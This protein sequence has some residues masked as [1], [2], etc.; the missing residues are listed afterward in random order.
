MAIAHLQGVGVGQLEDDQPRRPHAVAAAA[1]VLV[2]GPQDHA[3][4][5]ADA[6]DAAV[7]RGAEDD[8]GE[9]R[10]LLQPA[11]RGQ[12]NLR[13]LPPRHRLLA[14]LSAGHL[15]VLLPQRGHHVA[16]REVPRSKLLRVDPDPH[17]VIALA[18]DEDVADPRQ[19]EQLVADVHQR[20]VAQVELVV[21][22]VGRLDVDAH[23][24]VGH[25]LAGRHASLLDDVG[26]HRQS[27]VHPVLHQYLGQVQVHALVESHGKT[28][29]AVVGGLRLHVEH[30]LDAVDLLLDGRGHRLGHHLGAGAGIGATDLHR[31]RRD[32]RVLGQGQIRNCQPAG[33]RDGDRQHAGKDRPVNEKT[34]K[35]EL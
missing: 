15:R 35:H 32:R 9:L 25:P 28:V 21:A 10:R 30:L 7:G 5:V 11:E 13:L 3:A 6:D 17:A 20:V 16:G 34:G 23:E 27:Q 2:L 31:R 33:Q 24:D 8:V 22:A 18:G 14:D 26:E 4:H 1:L 12:G 19:A 29:G